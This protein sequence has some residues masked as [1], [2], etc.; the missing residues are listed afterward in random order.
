MLWLL[1]KTASRARYRRLCKLAGK[2]LVDL[3]Q[4]DGGWWDVLLAE[5]RIRM[6]AQLTCEHI[7]YLHLQACSQALC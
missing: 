1:Q 7:M 5:I 2:G 6:H 3:Q 4:D